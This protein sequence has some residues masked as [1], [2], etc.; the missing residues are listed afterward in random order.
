MCTAFTRKPTPVQHLRLCGNQ[1][2][3]VDRFMHLGNCISNEPCLTEHDILTKR[4]RFITKCVEL[5]QE[6]H[7]ASGRTKLELNSIYNFHFTGS[8]IWN[9]FCKSAVA[10]ESTYNRSVKSMFNLP[11]ETHRNLIESVTRRNHLRTVLMS[12]FT[13]FLKQVSNSQKIVPKMLLS[14]IKYDA[15]SVTGSNIRKILLLS[16]KLNIGEVTKRDL[17]STKYHPLSQEDKWKDSL[18]NELI[19]ARDGVL[20]VGEFDHEE[21]ES[22]IAYLCIS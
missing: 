6:F 19:D 3:W 22:M 5:D 4:A 13:N 18:L 21:I 2:P 17:F 9:L 15:R 10:L 12:R 16:G 7:F 20:D 11:I 1:L 8:P 14:A